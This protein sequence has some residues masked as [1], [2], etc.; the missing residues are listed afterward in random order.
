MKSQ[1]MFIV[2]LFGIGPHNSH[3]SNSTRHSRPIK[4]AKGS[5][6]PCFQSKPVE[7]D[8]ELTGSIQEPPSWRDSAGTNSA[9]FSKIDFNIRRQ[10]AL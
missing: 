2:A 9:G 10:A 7:P 5:G 8:S 4:T 3:G 6:G 1:D